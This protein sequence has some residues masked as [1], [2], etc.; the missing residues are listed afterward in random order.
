MQAIFYT[1]FLILGSYV[2]GLDAQDYS[3]VESKNGIDMYAKVDPANGQE[4]TKLIAEIDASV[5]DITTYTAD[6]E[7]L[8]LGICLR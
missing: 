5:Y 7:N 8:S 2:T 4:W 1:F 3:F 6:V